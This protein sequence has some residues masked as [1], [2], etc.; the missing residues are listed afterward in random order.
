[1]YIKLYCETTPSPT[2]PHIIVDTYLSSC[3]AT[4]RNTHVFIHSAESRVTLQVGIR[5]S[6]CKYILAE[7]KTTHDNIPGAI[8]FNTKLKIIAAFNAD[9]LRACVLQASIAR[10]LHSTDHLIT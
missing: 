8:L 5:Q 3:Q 1:M 7:R 6:L 9:C 4:L 2:N 10:T